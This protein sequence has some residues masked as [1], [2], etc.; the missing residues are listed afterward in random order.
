MEE[1]GRGKK[2]KKPTI[3]FGDI[4]VCVKEQAREPGGLAALPG[5]GTR[6]PGPCPPPQEPTAASP[7]PRVEGPFAPGGGK[8]SPDVESCPREGLP[9][10]QGRFYGWQ[11][12]VLGSGRAALPPRGWPALGAPACV[13]TRARPDTPAPRR[14]GCLAVRRG[15][16]ST[17]A[18]KRKKIGEKGSLS[19]PGHPGE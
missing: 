16:G 7:P 3:R 9:G 15:A 5:V 6:G 14:E 11:R 19:V 13:G 4:D 18:K 2:K 10:R 1:G 12:E 17:G 8:F